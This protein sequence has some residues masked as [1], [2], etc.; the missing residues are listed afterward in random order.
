M[1]DLCAFLH[2]RVRA[3]AFCRVRLGVGDDGAPPAP[4]LR[5]A[6]TPAG[7]AC[8]G[9]AH[10]AR[11]SRLFHPLYA[12]S[13]PCILGWTSGAPRVCL[14]ERPA[15]LPAGVALRLTVLL[16]D[17]GSC[18]LA[19]AARLAARPPLT[20]PSS[21]P[22]FLYTLLPALCPAVAR[23]Q[24]CASKLDFYHG[25]QNTGAWRDLA[26][27]G[28]TRLPPSLALLPALLS[29]IHISHRAARG[30]G[31]TWRISPCPALFIPTADVSL[32]CLK[33]TKRV[34]AI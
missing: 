3:N 28:R 14:M 15:R 26:L 17:G 1:E 32:A 29:P 5:Y 30:K 11:H 34:L 19:G 20:T 21:L 31:V 27:P 4:S 22:L 33:R 9:G 12:A 25:V 10:R 8:L 23:R 18:G 6:S 13:A 24:G 7:R 2:S 16:R